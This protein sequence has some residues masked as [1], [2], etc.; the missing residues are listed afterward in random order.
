MI[1]TR[2]E[3]QISP[4]SAPALWVPLRTLKRPD[5]AYGERL[6]ERGGDL[7]D[8]ASQMVHQGREAVLLPS[9]TPHLPNSDFL[10]LIQPAQE[11]LSET[12][13][14]KRSH[15][16]AV[17]T[18]SQP[19][20]ARAGVPAGQQR[21]A[22]HFATG[23]ATVRSEEA[24]E[25]LAFGVSHESAGLTK[26]AAPPPQVATQ[27]NAQRFGSLR[28]MR[29]PAS[30]LSRVKLG[31]TDSRLLLFNSKY[32]TDLESLLQVLTNS[33]SSANMKQQAALRRGEVQQAAGWKEK[34][35][36]DFAVRAGVYKRLEGAEPGEA[37]AHAEA[38]F[39]QQ[40]VAAEAAQGPDYGS[41]SA[42]KPTLQARRRIQSSR[43]NW[44]ES[45]FA[46]P[47]DIKDLRSRDVTVRTRA[48]NRVKKPGSA[49]QG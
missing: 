15:S 11:S 12:R 25:N 8:L 34:Y 27:T 30:L 6:Y 45:P 17:H 26:V 39:Q 2:D 19:K 16:V 7:L 23:S 36:A 24:S 31:L 40:R 4:Q 1:T 28:H 47:D 21:I 46:Q 37:E 33:I 48:A 44:H 22:P 29:A 3:N 20:R 43:K 13:S 14:L 42:T 41:G 18:H 38:V 49:A 10:A 32:P 5:K 9:F 35:D